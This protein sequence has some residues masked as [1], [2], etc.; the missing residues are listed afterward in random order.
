M[1]WGGQWYFVAQTGSDEAAEPDTGDPAPGPAAKEKPQP[2]P[3]ADPESDAGD[4]KLPPLYIVPGDAS[5]TVVSDDAEALQQ[6]EELLRT[7][8]PGGGEI[9]RNISVFELKHSNA[10]DVAERLTELF[11]SEE[12]SWRR[13]LLPLTIVPD[14]RLNTI[15]VQGSRID[16][17]TI[18]S[19]VRVFDS[20]EGA[21]TKPQLVPLRYAE[22]SQVAEVIQNVFRSQ[23]TPGSRSRSSKSTPRQTPSVSVDEKTNSLIVMAA[24]PLLE[25][26]LQLA[27]KLDEAAGASPARQVKI[28]QLKKSSATRVEDALRKILNSGSTRTAG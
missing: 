9:G 11:N 24:S 2:K 23:L 22:A 6:F 21:A 10:V 4:P 16:R 3:V 5:I 27:N 15:I 17:E 14:E 13:G 1:A 18:E 20:D 19:L 12:S 25:E 8:L 7:L 28:I 26:I